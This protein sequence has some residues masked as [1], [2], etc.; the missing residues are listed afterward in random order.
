MS[1]VYIMCDH[2]RG[3]QRFLDEL[4]LGKYWSIFKAKGY[5]RE[6]DI[7]ELDDRDMDAMHIKPN[8]RGKLLRAGEFNQHGIT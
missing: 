2:H 6:S 5:D 4:D 1:V 8:D 7:V 3:V